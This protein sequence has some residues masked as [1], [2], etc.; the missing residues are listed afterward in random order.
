ME[1]IVLYRKKS[2]AAEII[3]AEGSTYFRPFPPGRLAAALLYALGVSF[4]LQPAVFHTRGNRMLT[5]LFR[6]ACLDCRDFSL[7]YGGAVAAL[8]NRW[9]VTVYGT[10]AQRETVELLLRSREGRGGEIEMI[11]SS[12]SGQTYDILSGLCLKIS[13]GTPMEA[14]NLAAILRELRPGCQYAAVSRI[15]EEFCRRQGML[16]AE[17]GALFCYVA[18]E[19]EAP[20]PAERVR[21]LTIS[22]KIELWRAFLEGGVSSREFDWLLSLYQEGA[23]AALL[24]WELALQSVLEELGFSILNEDGRFLVE[25]GRARRRKFDYAGGSPAEK[26]FLKILFP[27]GREG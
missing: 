27:I 23:G 8:S 21:N 19:E 26:M 13:C 14:W 9:P 11:Q 1:E 3:P 22:H 4:S 20:S 12:V 2:A 25:D 17:D 15:H 7:Q 5:V 6:D 16:E 24:E 10:A 18:M